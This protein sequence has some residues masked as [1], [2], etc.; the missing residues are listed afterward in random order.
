MY[1]VKSSVRHTYISRFPKADS[2]RIKLLM[3][4]LVSVLVPL[5]LYVRVDSR[6]G[7]AAVTVQAAGRGKQYFNFIDGRQMRVNF[8]GEQYLAEALQS[9]QAQ[10]RSL[11]SIVLSD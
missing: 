9:G 10:S 2:M 7:K 11:A 1:S 4:C 3:I 5:A 6:I 8:R